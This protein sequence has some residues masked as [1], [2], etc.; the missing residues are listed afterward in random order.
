MKAQHTGIKLTQV[1]VKTV[2]Q[3]KKKK[4]KLKGGNVITRSQNVCACTCVYTGVPWCDASRLKCQLLVMKRR[5]E[6]WGWGGSET[7]C[8]AKVKRGQVESVVVLPRGLDLYKM[9]LQ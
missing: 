3:K 2:M 4:K 6:G 8:R 1:M 7:K 9:F 5:R